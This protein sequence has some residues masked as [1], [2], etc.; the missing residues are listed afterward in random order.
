MAGVDL[1]VPVSADQHQ[2]LHIRLGQQILD[3]I[4]G[5]RV[6]PLQIVEEQC[7]RM[8][9]PGAKTPMKRRNTSLKRRCASCGESSETGGCSPRI[10]ASSGTRSTMSCPFGFNAS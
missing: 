9:G 8:L 2:V 1:V 3:Q 6:E 4:E 10:S 7:Q 5:G